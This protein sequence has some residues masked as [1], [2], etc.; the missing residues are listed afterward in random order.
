MRRHPIGYRYASA[1][2]ELT[3]EQGILETAIKEL[4]E[5]SEV[6]KDT[7]LLDEVFKHPKMTDDDK[8][9]ILRQAFS[10]KVSAAVLNLLL[11]LVDNK[12]LDVFH[13]IVDNFKQLANEARGVSE[14]TVYTAKPLNDQEQEAIASIFAKRAGKAQLILINEVDA[15]II[16]GL[17]VRIGDTV[18]DGSVANQLARIQS[19]MILGNVSR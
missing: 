6:F 16:G 13:A 3:Q 19:Q 15:D 5:V 18:Y 17:K 2:L 8:K 9:S 12:R 14:A 10:D 7:N 4:D 1:L 11:L